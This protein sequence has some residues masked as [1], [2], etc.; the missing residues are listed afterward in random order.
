M[1]INQNNNRK[2]IKDEIFKF[3]I[4]LNKDD[5]P[6]DWDINIAD[7]INGLLKR[8]KKIYIRI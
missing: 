3:K 4:N 5:I 8:K 6:S 1:L 2:E 7:L